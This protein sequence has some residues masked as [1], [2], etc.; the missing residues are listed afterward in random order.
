MLRGG[1]PQLPGPLL[2]PLFPDA[3]DSLHLMSADVKKNHLDRFRRVGCRMGF[4]QLIELRRAAVTWTEHTA[5]RGSYEFED[6][7]EEKSF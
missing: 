4:R 5:V 3:V 6:F 7:R 2:L 1:W